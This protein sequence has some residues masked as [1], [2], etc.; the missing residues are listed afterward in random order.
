[1]RIFVQVLTILE[2][3]PK[4]EGLTPIANKFNSVFNENCWIWNSRCPLIYDALADICSQLGPGVKDSH[5]ILQTN[6]AALFPPAIANRSIVPGLPNADEKL[7]RSRVL[8]EVENPITGKLI[9]NLIESC[10]WNLP[11]LEQLLQAVLLEKKYLFDRADEDGPMI[12]GDIIKQYLAIDFLYMAQS[13]LEERFLEYFA[14]VESTIFKDWAELD[15]NFGDLER[16]VAR[17]FEICSQE[18]G[19]CDSKKAAL[20]VLGILVFGTKDILKSVSY[21]QLAYFLSLLFECPALC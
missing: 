14:N 6:Y 1:M 9:R 2:T 8:F 18:F 13:T 17:L 20:I 15:C 21:S 7:T 19:T 3:I 12:L 16:L 5:Q 10:A 11:S 4:G